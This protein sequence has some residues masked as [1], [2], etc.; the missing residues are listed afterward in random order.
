MKKVNLILEKMKQTHPPLVRGIPEPKLQRITKALFACVSQD[1]AALEK[2]KLKVPGLGI[3]SVRTVEI[4]K[5]GRKYSAKRVRFALPKAGAIKRGK[6]TSADT[7]APK[8]EGN[9][10]SS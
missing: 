8:I 9:Q 4:E 2:G 3:F 10:T 1:I 5:G 7:A 6:E